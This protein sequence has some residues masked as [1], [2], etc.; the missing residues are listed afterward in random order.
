MKTILCFGDS[1][2]WGYNPENRQRFGPDE[3]WTG[4]L[5]NSLGEDYRVIE[6]GLNGRT[7]LW[8]DP[9]EGF[10]NGLDYL[11]P[12]LE[13]HKPFDLITIMLGTNDLKCRFSVSAFDIAESVGVLVRQVQQSQAGPQENAPIPLLIAPPPL[14]KLNE[15]EE[16]FKGGSK[17]SQLFGNYYR[18]KSPGN[19]LSI[20][21][22]CRI[23][24]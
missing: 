16:M 17:K 7:T 20:F 15:F 11:M 1:N 8:D 12:C 6:E 24:P 18:K 2:T 3:R 4:I 10:K 5:R 14:A 19:G 22:C 23:H 13:S 21:G 9:I